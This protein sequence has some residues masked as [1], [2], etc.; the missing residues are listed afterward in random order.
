MLAEIA[1]PNETF[2]D[3][4]DEFAGMDLPQIMRAIEAEVASLFDA[5]KFR[6]LAGLMRAAQRLGA[7]VSQIAMPFA[8]RVRAVMNGVLHPEAARLTLESRRAFVVVSKLALDVQVDVARRKAVDV[9]TAAG[10]VEMPLSAVSDSLLNR[11]LD[12]ETRR[13]LPPDKQALPRP[14]AKKPKPERNHQ[15][16]IELSTAE[17]EALQARAKSRGTSVSR[18]VRLEL[19]KTDLLTRPERG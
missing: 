6:R 16:I 18:L 7:D 3:C 4:A 1:T 15:V 14:Y 2:T 9:L 17:W 11:V 10:P 12:P 8:D 13:L 19:D 5:N